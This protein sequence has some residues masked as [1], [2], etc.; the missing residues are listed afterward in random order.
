MR[1]RARKQSRQSRLQVVAASA[2]AQTQEEIQAAKAA[3]RTARQVATR[4]LNNR[5]RA[6]LVSRGYELP[7]RVFS[8]LFV[9]PT[10]K[11]EYVVEDLG[12]GVWMVQGSERFPYKVQELERGWT[13]NCKSWTKNRWVDCK[14]IKYLRGSDPGSKK[15]ARRMRLPRVI[16]PEGTPS[17]FARRHRAYEK[18]SERLPLLAE[19]ICRRF[20]EPERTGRGRRPVPLR[21]RAY[22]LLMKVFFGGM[23]Y[24][25]LAKI[26][27][28]DEVACRLGLRGKVSANTLCAWAADERLTKPLRESI[29]I[30]ARPGH[31]IET[32][33]LI[34]GTGRPTTFSGDWFETKHGR[35]SKVR[36]KSKFINEHV[37]CGRTTGLVAALEISLDEGQGSADTVHFRTCVA[38]AADV[39]T[40]AKK[41]EGDK[42]YGNKG[43]GRWCQDNNFELITRAKS[44][45]KRESG[46]WPKMMGDVARRERTQPEAFL[47]EYGPRSRIEAVPSA[48][49]RQ[50][51]HRRLRRRFNDA[52]VAISP[53]TENK[54]IALTLRPQRELEKIVRRQ[55][56]A[57][58]TALLNEGYAIYVIDNLRNL[59]VHE[60]LHDT[61]VSFV[62]GNFGFEPIPTFDLDE[63][64]DFDHSGSGSAEI[65]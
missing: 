27:S 38:A 57:I 14:H 3:R 26:L 63:I 23:S 22:A 43:N 55:T 7:V 31:K 45:E 50:Y 58:G 9:P 36:A 64:D 13:C 10:A 56:D 59:V 34:D 16:Y 29:A 25:R 41:V 6:M 48:S 12:D 49:K 11:T 40:R 15:Q 37:V 19:S 17:E 65:A 60:E 52:A 53:T 47:R 33:M 8:R 21:A 44:N 28:E 30:T 61:Q 51:R 32:T 4:A 2:A 46:S 20:V 42:A 62:S 1:K 35:P 24:D 5:I 39:F 54:E 18:M